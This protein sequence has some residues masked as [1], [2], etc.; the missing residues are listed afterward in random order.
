MPVTK[1]LLLLF[2]ISLLA[3]CAEKSGVHG[4]IGDRLKGKDISVQAFYLNP[5]KSPQER[6]TV[7]VRNDSQKD[8]LIFPMTVTAWFKQAGK[9][10][11]TFAAGD[12]AG[13]AQISP[14]KEVML[15]GDL[16]NFDVAP[17]DELDKLRLSMANGQEVF[18]IN[19]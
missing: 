1:I 9:K 14:Q 7:N 13:N 3:G 2:S 11:R 10:E 8:Y 18:T 12:L 6:P 17:G 16:F 5:G 19:P 4:R 15:P